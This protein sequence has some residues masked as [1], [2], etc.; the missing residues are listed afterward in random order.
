MKTLS[1]RQIHVNPYFWRTQQQQEIDY[2]EDINGKLYA[3]EFKWN[4]AKK[5]R[6]S[7]T[8]TDN[9]PVERTM[10]VNRANYLDFLAAGF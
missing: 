2:I 8:F 1:Y 5:A 6:F 7:K 3:Y 9:Y 4:A 10:V